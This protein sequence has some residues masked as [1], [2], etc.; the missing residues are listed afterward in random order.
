MLTDVVIFDQ[1]GGDI[2]GCVPREP[3][4]VV[5]GAQVAVGAEVFRGGRRVLHY[6]LVRLPQAGKSRAS[7]T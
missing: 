4:V 5:R 3:H 1:T 2:G 7:R 6:F